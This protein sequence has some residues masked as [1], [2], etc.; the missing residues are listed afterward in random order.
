MKGFLKVLAWVLIT[1]A[2]LAL[3]WLFAAFVLNA[4]DE[5]LPA[6]AAHLMEP[7]VIGPDVLAN[8]NGFL[9]AVGLSAPNGMR[10]QD[11]GRALVE[12]RFSGDERPGRSMEA[13]QIYA[14]IECNP[15]AS[16]VNCVRVLGGRRDAVQAALAAYAEVDADYARLLVAPRYLAAGTLPSAEAPLPAFQWLVRAA[17]RENDRI[18]LGAI[19]EPAATVAQRIERKLA[20]ERRMLAGADTLVHKMIAVAV[21]RRTLATVAHVIAEAPAVAKELLGLQALT[22]PLSGTE[23]SMTRVFEF[24]QRFLVHTLLER[25]APWQDYSAGSADEPAWSGRVGDWFAAR[26]YRRNETAR[27]NLEW[28][29]ALDRWCS[30]QIGRMAAGQ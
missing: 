22:T 8:D 30:T 5:Q 23:L 16:L 3:G 10:A 13:D 19:A 15:L 9:I 7:V 4:F 2:M 12:R 25:T 29:Q 11:Y 14:V 28:V 17:V 20:Q 24:E 18:M 21:L 27:I 26:L 1:P 6:Q